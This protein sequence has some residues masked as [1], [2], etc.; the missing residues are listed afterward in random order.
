MR[1]VKRVKPALARG[2]E[3][4]DAILEPIGEEEQC[5]CSETEEFEFREEDNQDTLPGWTEQD[6]MAGKR[7]SHR[8]PGIYGE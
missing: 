2:D 4:V 8:Q 6:I 7:N 1:R 3:L 5:D